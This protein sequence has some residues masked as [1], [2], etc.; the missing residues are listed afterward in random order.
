[1]GF[2]FV[3]GEAQRKFL[4][5]SATF[6]CA[7]EFER[8]VGLAII[9]AVAAAEFGVVDQPR[10]IGRRIG[11]GQGFV[12]QFALLEARVGS[13]VSGVAAQ[14]AAVELRLPSGFLTRRWETIARSAT[15]R[16][17]KSAGRFSAGK[18]LMM[19]FSA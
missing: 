2:F 12:G 4:E 9:L 16:S 1:M 7:V 18:K 6:A 11:V 5:R 8:D 17:R 19:R 10:Q 15:D 3:V 13:E 14:D